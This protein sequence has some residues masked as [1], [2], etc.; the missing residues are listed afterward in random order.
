MLIWL[1]VPIVAL[2]TMQALF[3]KAYANWAVTAYSAGTILAVWMLKDTKRGL[4]TSLI[5]NGIRQSCCPVL[6][7]FAGDLKLPN[8]ELVMKRYVGRSAISLKVADVAGQAHLDTIVAD[9]RD[10]LA[11]LFYTLK[12]KP[13]ASLRPQ[14]RRLPRQLL[15]ADVLPASRHQRQTCSYVA[16]APLRL[17]R[18]RTLNGD[19]GSRLRLHEGQDALRL[20]RSACQAAC[21]C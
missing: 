3:A 5:I 9:N 20:Q 4:T 12:G 13:Y 19:T 10:I 15:R 17:P 1:S 8:G 11:D 6:T 16:T 7:V 18:R 21:A 2:I 14:L